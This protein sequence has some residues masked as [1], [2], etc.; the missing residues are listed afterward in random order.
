MTGAGV[1]DREPNRRSA[2]PRVL[3]IVGVGLCGAV[4][5]TII[6]GFSL[7]VDADDP[8]DFFEQAIR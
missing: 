8:D 6:F 2:V 1:G 5:W 3:I 4:L 7:I